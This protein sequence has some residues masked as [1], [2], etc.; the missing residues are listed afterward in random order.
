[1]TVFWVSSSMVDAQQFRFPSLA[2]RVK[3]GLPWSLPRPFCLSPGFSFPVDPYRTVE[4]RVAVSV[5]SRVFVGGGAT[6][7]RLV[8]FPEGVC[9]CLCFFSFY[10]LAIS[11]YMRTSLAAIGCRRRG[12]TWGHMS[13]LALLV[14]PVARS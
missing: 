8:L 11:Q 10:E 14:S 6:H 9:V 1:M 5:A 4:F 3:R 7:T 2:P 13:I 12:K